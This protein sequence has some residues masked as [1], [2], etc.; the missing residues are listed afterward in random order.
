MKVL[1]L[2]PR[3][4]YWKC[5]F[6]AETVVLLLKL[7]FGN[8]NSDSNIK[9]AILFLKLGFGNWNSDSNIETA[10]LFLKLGFGNW[11][12]DSNIEVKIGSLKLGLTSI[13]FRTLLSYYRRRTDL[14]VYFRIR[15]FLYCWSCWNYVFSTSFFLSANVYARCFILLFI[16]SIA[17][18]RCHFF[19]FFFQKFD[20]TLISCLFS[21]NP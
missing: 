14:H 12:S 20:G 16:A 7:G 4:Q 10:I 15:C 17:L 3:L 5:G 6:E 11:N 8:W 9:T 19:Y 21:E 1:I 13:G 18:L 2:K